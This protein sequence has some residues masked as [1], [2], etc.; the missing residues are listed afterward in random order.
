MDE[1]VTRLPD[2]GSALRFLFRTVHHHAKVSLFLCFMVDAY[3]SESNSLSLPRVELAHTIRY[4]MSIVSSDVGC[5][6]DLLSCS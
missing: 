1:T 4:V 2:G 5:W 6:D 3:L